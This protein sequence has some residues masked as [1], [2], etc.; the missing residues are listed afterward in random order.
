MFKHAIMLDRMNYYA[1]GELG[2]TRRLTPEGFLLC[3]GVA[4][5]RTGEQRYSAQEVPVDAGPDGVVTVKRLPE[6]V[7]REET[8]ASFE[9]KPITVE[10]PNSF[11]TPGTWRDVSVGT[12]QNVRR[13]TGIEDD[14][15]LADLLITAEDAIKYVNRDLPELSSGYDAEY[16]QTEVGH[17]IQR[18]IIGNHV[19]LVDRGRAGPRCSI[20]DSKEEIFMPAGKY[21]GRIARILTA[22]QTKDEKALENEL[23]TQDE[24]ELAAEAMDARFQS[25]DEKL[26]EVIDWMKDRKARDAAE[27][28]A[29]A[30]EKKEKEDEEKAAKDALLTAETTAAP[31][32]GT[33]LT[34][35]FTG[36]TMKSIISRAEII[37]PGIK[38]P[39]GDAADGKAAIGLMQTALAAAYAQPDGKA[40]IDTFTIGKGPSKLT[41]DALVTVFNAV[42]EVARNANNGRARPGPVKVTDFGKPTATSD[43][44]K[45]AKEFWKQQAG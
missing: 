40:L 1:P 5:A 4:I 42:A 15:L 21:A 23:K 28:E 17:A 36:D 34:G 19:A 20:K 44:A 7:F 14:L 9:G 25:I 37:A 12:V 27:E 6:D 3:E 22:F 32:L 43:V 18:N 41:G 29:E 31:D 26:K 10:H 35:N 45:N 11:V 38:V 16:E 8:I 24:E 30:A 2:K 39:T 33:L 13:G